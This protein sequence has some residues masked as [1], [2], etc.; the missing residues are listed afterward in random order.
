VNEKYEWFAAYHPY[1]DQRDIIR[2]SPP[3]TLDECRRT[4]EGKGWSP[5]WQYRGL[6]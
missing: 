5:S 3:V 2:F 1:P 4:M 6:E